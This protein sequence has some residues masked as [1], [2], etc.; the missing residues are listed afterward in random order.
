[1]E[2]PSTKSY[3]SSKRH[4]GTG[5]RQ[6]DL[7]SQRR[8]HSG[9]IAEGH[10]ERSIA[11]GNIRGTDKRFSPTRVRQVSQEGGRVQGWVGGPLSHIATWPLRH[12][13]T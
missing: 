4:E 13:A 8:H 10:H 12:I 2:E 7:A 6:L 9:K 11:G 5:I 3:P 1:M